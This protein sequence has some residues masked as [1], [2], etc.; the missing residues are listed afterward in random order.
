MAALPV[1]GV[2]GAGVAGAALSGNGTPMSAAGNTDTTIPPPGYA[3][4]P[5]PIMPPNVN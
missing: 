1:A 5:Q 2:I 4:T 3:P